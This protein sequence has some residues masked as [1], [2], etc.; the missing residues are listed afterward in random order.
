[1]H[2]R[3]FAGAF[4]GFCVHVPSPIDGRAQASSRDVKPGSR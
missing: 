2:D 4:V 1:V 3:T